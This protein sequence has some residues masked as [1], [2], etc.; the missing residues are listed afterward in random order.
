M[1]EKGRDVCVTVAPYVERMGLE[2]LFIAS[3]ILYR[4]PNYQE[5]GHNNS[6]PSKYQYQVI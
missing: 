5:S 4:S 6:V 2:L 3:R 1:A